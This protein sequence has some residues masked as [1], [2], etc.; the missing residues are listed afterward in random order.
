MKQRTIKFSKEKMLI[1]KDK[2]GGDITDFKK[3][4][5]GENALYI[6]NSGYYQS[7][8]N[9]R[10]YIYEGSGE[11]NLNECRTRYDFTGL[12]LVYLDFYLS[13]LKHHESADK[14]DRDIIELYAEL[15]NKHLEGDTRIKPPYFEEIQQK[16][17]K[18]LKDGE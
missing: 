5:E 9:E 4:Y 8:E 17:L 18:G 13:N 6:T 12:N 10:F 14:A 1:L 16:L 11:L 15:L 7:R 2:F 3:F